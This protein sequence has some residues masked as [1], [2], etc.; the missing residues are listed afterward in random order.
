MGWARLVPRRLAVV[1]E[2]G[3]LSKNVSGGVRQ[4]EVR[5]KKGPRAGV[6]GIRLLGVVQIDGG[7]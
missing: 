7:L 4:D 2:P 3:E 6:G 1:Q 5:S